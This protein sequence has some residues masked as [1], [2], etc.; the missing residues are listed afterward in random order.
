MVS[1]HFLFSD[2][3]IDY[4]EQNHKQMHHQEYFLNIILILKVGWM[5]PFQKLLGSEL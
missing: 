2:F 5:C 4:D 3:L 1:E